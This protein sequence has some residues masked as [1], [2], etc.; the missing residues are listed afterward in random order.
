LI[1]LFFCAAL[2]GLADYCERPDLWRRHK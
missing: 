1:F 2:W